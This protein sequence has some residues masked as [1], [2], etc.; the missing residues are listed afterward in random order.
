[1]VYVAVS[2]ARRAEDSDPNKAIIADTMKVVSCLNAGKS[3][4]WEYFSMQKTRSRLVC[5]FFLSVGTV[6]TVNASPTK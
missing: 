3:R 1:M 5:F 6:H 2:D 4:D